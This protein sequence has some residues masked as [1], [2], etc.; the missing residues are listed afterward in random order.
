M[1]V[2]TILEPYITDSLT[3]RLDPYGHLIVTKWL[4]TC[5]RNC[6]ISKQAGKRG[7]RDLDQVLLCPVCPGF[8]RYLIFISKKFPPSSVD[9]AA[10]DSLIL[11]L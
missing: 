4:E 8:A 1:Y 3:Y 5:G 6:F 10:T 11:A 9:D 7:V 2:V